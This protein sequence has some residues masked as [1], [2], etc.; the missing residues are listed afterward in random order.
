VL[1]ELGGAIEGRRVL[2]LGCGAGA[3]TVALLELTDNVVGVDI[4]PAMVE[5]CRSTLTKGT[6]LVGD[7][8]DLSA[9]EPESYDVVVAGANLIDVA[10]H[11]ERPRVLAEIRR[12]LPRGGLLYF[13]SHNRSSTD[14]LE[15]ARHGPSLRLRGRPYAVLRALLAYVVGALHHRRLARRQVFEADYAILNDSAHHFGLLH[16]YIT[17]AAQERELEETGFE[18]VAVH[19]MDGR[20]LAPGEDDAQFTELHYTARAV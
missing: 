5:Y 16:H 19:G 6:F 20:R 7:V 15:Q 4:S 11:A 18:L 1:A 2:E 3:I 14:A 17:R 10:T 9:H 13:S 12:V 8:H